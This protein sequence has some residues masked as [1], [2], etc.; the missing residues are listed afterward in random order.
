[1]QEDGNAVGLILSSLQEA[2]AMSNQPCPGHF[3]LLCYGASSLSSGACSKR[4]S[5]L[6]AGWRALGRHSWAGVPEAGLSSSAGARETHLQ[7]CPS[8]QQ[9]PCTPLTHIDLL[10]P[11]KPAQIH[12]RVY[13]APSALLA[14]P[15]QSTPDISH[16]T[17]V[18][19]SIPDRASI[20]GSQ[21]R[22]RG[23]TEDSLLLYLKAQLSLCKWI[24]G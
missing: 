22:H 19:G 9:Q 10:Q 17:A 21:Q 8:S 13:W 12:R 15:T 2:P 11:A 24:T 18:L 6:S 23:R 3:S 5:Q 20:A 14:Q 1:M 4:G 16:R 7:V